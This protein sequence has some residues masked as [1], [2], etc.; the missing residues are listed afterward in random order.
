M[1]TLYT[2]GDSWTQGDELGLPY[3]EHQTEAVELYWSW[4]WQL[5]KLLGTSICVNEARKGTSN[6]RIFRRT[7]NFINNY[8]KKHNVEDLT[9]VVCWTTLDRWEIPVAAQVQNKTTPWFMPIQQYGVNFPNTSKISKLKKDIVTGL[10]QLY[11]PYTMTLP[12]NKARALAQYNRMWQ[13]KQICENLNI[14]LVQSFALDV[15]EF[16]STRNGYI[17]EWHD[18]IGYVERAFINHCREINCELAPG[19]HPLQKGHEEW[20]KLIFAKYVYDRI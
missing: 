2:N 17:K 9:V 8:S 12:S 5:H 15:T 16:D 20:A 1:K 11:K 19:G 7:T 10:E 18:D 14:K 3:V 4:P 13:L 6:E